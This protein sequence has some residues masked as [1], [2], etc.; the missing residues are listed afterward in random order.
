MIH[1]LP[2][3]LP[4][5]PRHSP[6]LLHFP[7]P[8]LYIKLPANRMKTA[9]LDY[10][11]PPERIAQHPCKPRDAARL[12]LIDRKTGDILHRIFRDLPGYL[13]AGD[14]LVLNTTKVL[15]ARFDLRRTTG[16]RIEALFIRQESPGLWSVM[17]TGAGKLREGERLMVSRAAG[18]QGHAGESVGRAS[19]PAEAGRD[20]GPTH[21][22]EGWSFTFQRHIERGRCELR[23]DPPDD[24]QVVLG[25]IGSA[26]LPP[27]I[28]RQRGRSDEPRPQVDDRNRYQ[29][30][31]AREAG[32]VAAPTA[33]LHFTESLLD[34]IRGMGVEMAEVVLHV[35]LGTF[36]PIEVDDLSDHPMHSEWYALSDG[37]AN[38]ID[39]ARRAGGRIIPVGTTSVR[40]L[41]TVA[42]ANSLCHKHEPSIEARNGW[43]NLLIQPPYGFRLAD[44]LITNFHLPR[45]TLLALVYAF[46]GPNLVRRAYQEAIEREYRF[47]SYGDAMLLV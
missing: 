19:A 16:G 7:P 18:P 4:I 35:G 47:Y 5:L 29:T 1:S 41:E 17:L 12:M 32:A 43:T 3:P 20:A 44:A 8:R 40:V 2:T 31:Y 14:C 33:G 15:P 24:P 30:V 26:P 42:Q 6:C 34:R 13:H 23:V 28:H 38:T 21:A 45:S 11:L 39:Q 37:A 27:Y 25:H 46:A 10:H 22:S 9:D 36:Q